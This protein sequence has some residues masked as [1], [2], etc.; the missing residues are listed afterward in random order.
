VPLYERLGYEATTNSA[1]DLPDGRRFRM[2]AMR[3][4]IETAA[5]GRTGSH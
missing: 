1:I 5:R 4:Q 2:V 3:K